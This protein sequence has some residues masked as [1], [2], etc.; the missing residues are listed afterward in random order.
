MKKLFLSLAF[1]FS[2]LVPIFSQEGYLE[3]VESNVHQ[4]TDIAHASDG[5][6]RLF[7]LEKEGIVKTIPGADVFLDISEQVFID[8]T[9][10]GLLGIAFHPDFENNN[11]F[12]L[13]YSTNI[14]GSH[15]SRVSRFQAVN[16]G[17]SGD[18]ETETIILEL[19]QP[20]D[21]HNGGAM[22]FGNDGYLYIATGD[23]GGVGDPEMNAQDLESLH[24]KILRIDVDQGDPYGIPADNPFVNEGNALGEV[25]AFG[26]RNPWKISKDRETGGIWIADVGQNHREEIN[27]LAIG[28][29]YGWNF[30]EGSLCYPP[31]IDCE[32]IGTLPVFE[33]S[34]HEED[35]CAIIGGYVYRG[36]MNPNLQGHYI[37]GD[38][39]SGNVWALHEETY[40]NTLLFSTDFMISTFGE[41]EDGELYLGEYNGA[42]HKFTD[43]VTSIEESVTKNSF[44]VF[45]NPAYQS[46]NVSFSKVMAEVKIVDKLGIT[47]RQ[48]APESKKININDLSLKTGVYVVQMTDASGIIYTQKLLISQ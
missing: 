5:S 30:M 26:L 36:S 18:P 34:I 37:Y 3:L 38:F 7:V 21:N 23:G 10:M 40:E 48:Y 42:I 47:L 46:I 22:L 29:N 27:L 43:E 16:D 41:D 35:E 45:P 1:T 31:D 8:H 44:K 11:Y 4:P 24:G 33:Y 15:H 6:G 39:C 13:Y 14:D 2:C 17:Q 19:E 32:V 20:F 25:Y 9:E 12:Y 28:T